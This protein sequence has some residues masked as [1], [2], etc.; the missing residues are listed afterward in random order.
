MNY[1]NTSKYDFGPSDRSLSNSSDG[2]TEVSPK[3][4]G[5]FNDT[6]FSTSGSSMNL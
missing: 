2:I 5:T 4:L 1:G 3:N 6:L